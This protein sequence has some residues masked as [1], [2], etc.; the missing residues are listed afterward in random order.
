MTLTDLSL[1]NLVQEQSQVPDVRHF[2]QVPVATHKPRILLLY[3]SLRERSYSRLVVEECVRLLHALGAEPRVFDPRDLPLPDSCDASHP[4]VQELRDLVT[5]SE[6][7][8]WCSPERHGAMTGIMKTQIDWIPLSLGAVRPS[9]GKTLA[10]MQVCGGSQSFN[11][12]NQLRVLGR[13]MRMLTIPNQSSVA[14]AHLEFDEAGRMKP[15]SYYERIVDVME[16]LVKFT[17]LTRDH[18]DYLV[19]RYSERVESAE[20]LSKRVNQHS[21]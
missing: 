19:D 10:V 2:R 7:Q 17:L 3:G 5:W 13:W 8:V 11:A 9:Q 14:K 18:K 15:S 1:P 6:G 20:A 12:V 4:K 21:L 16:E